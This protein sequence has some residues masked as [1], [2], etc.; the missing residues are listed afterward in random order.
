MLAALCLAAAG[1]EAL[2][3]DFK[4]VG[5]G[6]ALMYDA[7]SQKS[8]KLYAAPAGMPVEIVFVNGDWTRVRDAGGDLSW[9]ESRSLLPR[10]TLVVEVQQA[11][12]R[13]AASD[14]APIVF[15]AGKGVLLELA[16]PVASGWIK[17]RHRDGET[18]YVKA[19]DVWGE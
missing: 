12:A 3:A 14:T 17:V 2:A 11:S 6:P 13:A 8:R 9:I 4:S 5:P 16:E 15:N 10:R 7:P 19:A 1:S 18:G